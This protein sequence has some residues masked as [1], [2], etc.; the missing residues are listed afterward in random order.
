MCGSVSL[1]ESRVCFAYD[2]ACTTHFVPILCFRNSEL[3]VYKLVMVVNVMN[4]LFECLVFERQGKE[5][6]LKG[7]QMTGFNTISS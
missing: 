3:Q 5:S 1:G 7:L 4:R 2:V 6:V